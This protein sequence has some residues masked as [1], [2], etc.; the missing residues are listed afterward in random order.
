MSTVVDALRTLTQLEV[1][2]LDLVDIVLVAILFYLLLVVVKGTRGTS[3]LWGCWCSARPTW[4]P[5]GRP[6]HTGDGARQTLFTCRW[7]SSSS[8]STRSAASSPPSAGRRRC[9]GWAACRPARW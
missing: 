1:G 7:S 5:V 4:P 3:M 9:A 2:V 6:D 8:S